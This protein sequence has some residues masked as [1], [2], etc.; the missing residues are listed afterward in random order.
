MT[1][2][3]LAQ[4]IGVSQKDISRWENGVV[5]PSVNSLKQLAIAL[6]CKV[7]DIV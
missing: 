5:N 2:S 4:K 1:Q 7:D 3:E 6:D